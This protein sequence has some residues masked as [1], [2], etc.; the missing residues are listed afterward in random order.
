MKKKELKQ[1][2]NKVAK[3]LYDDVVSMDYDNKHFIGIKKHIAPL[4]RI[5]KSQMREIEQ[6]KKSGNV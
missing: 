3:N 1:V 4:I 2:T 6:L 5:I